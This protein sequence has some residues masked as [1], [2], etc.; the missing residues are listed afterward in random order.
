LEYNS[1]NK[2]LKKLHREAEGKLVDFCQEKKKQ[3][4]KIIEI[5]NENN[6]MKIN[7][8]KNLNEIEDFSNE[9]IK[10]IDQKIFDNKNLINLKNEENSKKIV[11]K[12]SNL[13]DE[14][15]NEIQ[16]ENNNENKNKIN[17]NL[18]N[19]NFLINI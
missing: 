18:N 12:F 1:L 2:E 16:I 3:K 9:I 11:S 7:S 13:D 4:N 15:Q 14:I 19:I 5:E 6:N 10:N 8:I 17:E